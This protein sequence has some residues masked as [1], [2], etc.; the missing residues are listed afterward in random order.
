MGNKCQRAKV[1]MFIFSFGVPCRWL[2][3]RHAMVVVLLTYSHRFCLG[4]VVSF[5]CAECCQYNLRHRQPKHFHERP[6]ERKSIYQWVLQCEVTASKSIVVH[7]DRNKISRRVGS[8]IL[9]PLPSSR[10]PSS[11]PTV[12]VHT[13]G[14]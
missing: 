9:V 1:Q 10:I 8:A 14:T 6:L 7:H 3:T 5:Q 11:P 13:T 2:Q 4:V 12:R